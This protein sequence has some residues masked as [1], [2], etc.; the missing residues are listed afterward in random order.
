MDS[1]FKKNVLNCETKVVRD[2]NDKYQQ[3]FLCLYFV[4]KETSLSL[5]FIKDDNVCCS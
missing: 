1:H 2:Y 3:M 5:Q 4:H